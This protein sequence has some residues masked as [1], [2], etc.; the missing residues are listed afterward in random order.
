MFNKIKEINT[1]VSLDIDNATRNKLLNII[2]LFV[3]LSWFAVLTR[4]C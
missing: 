1:E 4:G 2:G 3:L